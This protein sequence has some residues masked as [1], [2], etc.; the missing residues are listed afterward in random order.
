MFVAKDDDFEKKE[1]KVFSIAVD[2][3]TVGALEQKV[4]ELASKDEVKEENKNE[5]ILMTTNFY[6]RT[7]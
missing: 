3:E 1:C 4:L 5:K 6:F 2:K 7:G